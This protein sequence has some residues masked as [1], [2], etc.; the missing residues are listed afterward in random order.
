MKQHYIYMTT[1]NIT[2]MKYI[3]KH[4]GELNDAYLGSGTI[5]KKAI[6]KYGKE[7]FSKT[8]LFISS[9]EEENCLKEKEYIA[10]YQATTN[11]EFY[12]L[13][14]G[15]SGGNTTAGY[16]EAEKQALKN[17]LSILNT[18]AG[19]GMYGKHHTEQTKQLLSYWAEFQRD[20]SVYRTE[21]FREKM[22]QLTSGKNNGMYGKTHSEEAKQ[23][24]SQNSIGKTSGEKNGMY[25]KSGDNAI[26]GKK[27]GMFDENDN[28]IRVFNA[29]TAVL[30]F[31]GLKGHGQ[32]NK[33]IKNKTLYKGYYW[34][35]LETKND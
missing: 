6:A 5:L 7:N 1:N 22:S 17:K 14:E 33:A 2:K 16:T 13:H 19:N 12:N 8:I 21:E 28:L 20:N 15:G 31:L 23:K 30:N 32:L 10:Y 3:G 9:S 34:K 4:F 27:V 24:M 11:P 35:I 25:G 26:N 18:G 29:K